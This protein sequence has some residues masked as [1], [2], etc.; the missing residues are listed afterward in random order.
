MTDCPDDEPAGDVSSPACSMHE[1]DDAYMGYVGKDELIAFL[2]E[3]LEAESAGAR[4]TLESARAAG[5][6]PLAELMRTIHRDEAHWC[7][8]LIRH[9]KTPRRDALAENR[10]FL[11]QSHGDRRSRRAYRFPQSRPRLGGS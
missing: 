7:A 11:R 8:M 2:N 1:A 3:L 4:V 10:R 6:G 5:T 9:I